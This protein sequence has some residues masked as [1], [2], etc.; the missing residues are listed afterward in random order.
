MDNFPYLFAAY[1][2]IWIVFYFFLLRLYKREKALRQELEELRQ[3]V[4][5]SGGHSDL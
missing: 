5:E 3:E 4:E 1:N 2:I